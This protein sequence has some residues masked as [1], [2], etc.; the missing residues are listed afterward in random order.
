M[1]DLPSAR[2]ERQTE[3]Q[4]QD[5]RRLLSRQYLEEVDRCNEEFLATPDDRPNSGLR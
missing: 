5:A 4:I 3:L 1:T 2:E